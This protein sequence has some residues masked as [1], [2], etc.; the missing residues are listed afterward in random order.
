[1][2]LRALRVRNSLK[3]FCRKEE[4][5]T[6]IEFILW[7]PIFV[8]IVGLVIDLCFLFLAQS[9]LYDVTAEGVRR[10]AVLQIKTG[11]E[12]E[13]FVEN[14]VQFR[15]AP[16]SATASTAGGAVIITATMDPADIVLTGVLNIVA[17]GSISATVVQLQEGF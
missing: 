12:A 14:N 2:S 4:G 10:W 15:G 7:I 8:I 6:T 16:V 17:G 5:S 3:K 1:M 13:T 11:T 9:R